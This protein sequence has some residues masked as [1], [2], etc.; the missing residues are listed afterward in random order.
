MIMDAL[1]ILPNQLHKRAANY[2]WNGKAELI[3]SAPLIDFISF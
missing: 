1:F 2:E 3:T